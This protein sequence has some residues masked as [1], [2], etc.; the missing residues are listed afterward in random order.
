MNTVAEAN[1][2]INTLINK[3]GVWASLS[4]FSNEELASIETYKHVIHVFAD[5]SIQIHNNMMQLVKEYKT[6]TSTVKW[7]AE[8]LK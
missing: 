8:L 4:K 3:E 7:I 6:P 1:K 2:M 5:G